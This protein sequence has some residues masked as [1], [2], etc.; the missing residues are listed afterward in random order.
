MRILKLQKFVWNLIWAAYCVLLLI[1]IFLFRS[2]PSNICICIYTIFVIFT[3]ALCALWYVRFLVFLIF[4]GALYYVCVALSTHFLR[5]LS[6]FWI[7]FWWWR[8]R[9]RWRLFVVILSCFCFYFF[10]QHMKPQFSF[11][12]FFI[13]NSWTREE[14]KKSIA[15]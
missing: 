6:T 3:F 5:I 1:V 10:A 4:L 12:I 15:A 9:R 14:R 8:R 2:T 13:A 11:V 7:E